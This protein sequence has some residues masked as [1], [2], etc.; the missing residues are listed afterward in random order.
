LLPEDV[1][2]YLLVFGLRYRKGSQKGKPVQAGTVRDAITAVAKGFTNLDRPDPRVN[3]KTGKLHSVLTDFY[4]SME[5][6]DDP[7]SRA[8]PVN[9]T[10]IRELFSV[11]DIDD[12]VLGY[13]TTLKAGQLSSVV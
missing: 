11:L 6:D 12:P 7:T 2:C 1:I 8:Y 5:R 4:R 9:I 10:I 3:P 13:C